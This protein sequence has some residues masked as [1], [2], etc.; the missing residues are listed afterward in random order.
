M[1][2]TRPAGPRAPSL[3]TA[4]S[5]SASGARAVSPRAASVRIARRRTAGRGSSISRTSPSGVDRVPGELEPAR[6]G[7]M[8]RVLAAHA[9]DRAEH[10]GLVELRGRAAELVPAA[11]IHDQ[12]AAVGV[13]EHVGRVEVEV[14]AG[15]EVLVLRREGRPLGGQGVPA[16]LV[17]VEV[18]GEEVVPVRLAERGRLV[19]SQAARRR[20][21]H[22]RAGPA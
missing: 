18:A 20:R 8:R 22:V 7:R 21:A 15:D 13:L 1:P 3:S 14:G 9:V 17:E 6:V 12:E 10:V 19:S 16:D 4:R 11:G 5:R 2:S